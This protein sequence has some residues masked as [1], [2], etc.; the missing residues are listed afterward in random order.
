MGWPLLHQLPQDCFRLA[1]D[2][3]VLRKRFQHRRPSP[4]RIERRR[5]QLQRPG[6]S[7]IQLLESGR[8]DID[9]LGEKVV[10][11]LRRDC[12]ALGLSGVSE[13]ARV[14]NSSSSFIRSDDRRN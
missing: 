7:L 9:A 12:P 5:G 8:G 3:R 14:V 10:A 11:D 6:R 4:S 2:T 1:L 13:I